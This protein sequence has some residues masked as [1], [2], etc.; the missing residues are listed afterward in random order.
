MTAN[1]VFSKIDPLV[2]PPEVRLYTLPN[3][4]MPHARQ[5]LRIPS[6]ESFTISVPR[7]Q[8]YRAGVL[9]DHLRSIQHP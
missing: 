9:R 4:E 2:L 8:I 3:T 6:R 5:I 7:D 1:T